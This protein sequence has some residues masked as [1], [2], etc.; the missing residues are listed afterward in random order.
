MT[1]A[2]L[3]L[4]ALPVGTKLYHGTASLD[5]ETIRAPAWFTPSLAVAK[6]YARE[7]RLGAH[8]SEIGKARVLRFVVARELHLVSIPDDDAQLRLAKELSA[9]VTMDLDYWTTDDDEELAN[10]LCSLG[11]DGW[12]RPHGEAHEMMLCASALGGIVPAIGRRIR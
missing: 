8:W 5:F 1:M 3:S 10:E 2:D 9:S 6:S 7:M 4:V 12:I 11:V